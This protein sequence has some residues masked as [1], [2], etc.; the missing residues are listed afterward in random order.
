MAMDPGGVKP[1]PVHS[2]GRRASA[3]APGLFLKNKDVPAVAAA[4]ACG[5]V[6]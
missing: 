6:G 5:A 4:A 1:A 2:D 3:E